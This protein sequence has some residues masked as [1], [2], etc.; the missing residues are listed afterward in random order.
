MAPEQ[1]T[2]SRLLI[3]QWAALVGL[4]FC[5][6]ISGS[7]LLGYW[8]RGREKLPSGIVLSP[9]ELVAHVD[10][11]RVI[12]RVVDSLQHDPPASKCSGPRQVDAVIFND[13]KSR[14]HVFDGD[15]ADE[16]YVIIEVRGCTKGPLLLPPQSSDG[17]MLWRPPEHIHIPL[18]IYLVQCLLLLEQEDWSG[19]VVQELKGKQLVRYQAAVQ[20]RYWRRLWDILLKPFAAQR[21]AYRGY[22]KAKKAPDLFF[23]VNARFADVV[24][25]GTTIEGSTTNGHDDVTE[26]TT[27]EGST[28]N[29][30]DTELG[31]SSSA[32]DAE[33]NEGVPLPAAAEWLEFWSQQDFPQRWTFIEFAS[34]LGEVNLPRRSRSFPDLSRPAASE[35]ENHFSF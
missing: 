24:T 22:H 7:L 19:R 15:T 16:I 23:G 11:L 33:M 26:G 12:G 17:S 14:I 34:N 31:Q 8:F 4:L 13:Q 1:Q 35:D 9:A 28:T 25:E 32:E 10:E 6:A 30:H 29:G 21:T 5:I 3:L 20:E 2:D 27:I 18:S